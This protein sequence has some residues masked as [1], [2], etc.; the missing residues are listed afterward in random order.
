MDHVKKNNKIS[1]MPLLSNEEFKS[2]IEI[3]TKGT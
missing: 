1:E 3:L 2:A